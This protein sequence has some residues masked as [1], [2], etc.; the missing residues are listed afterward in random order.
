MAEESA[1]DALALEPAAD[2][3]GRE[4]QLF[5][6]LRQGHQLITLGVSYRL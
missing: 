1:E 2:L 4:R 5:D 3:E 6:L